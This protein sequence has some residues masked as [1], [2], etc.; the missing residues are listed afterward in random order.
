M[1]DKKQIKDRITDIENQMSLQD[2]WNDSRKAQEI[3]AEYQSLKEELKSGSKYS[4]NNAIVSIMAGAGG[5]DAEDFVTML[6]RMYERWATQHGLSVE[7]LSSTTSSAGYRSVSFLIVGSGAYGKLKGE[8]GVH[9]LVRISP[10]NAQGKRQTSFA[11]VE[12]VPE[13]KALPSIELN[14]SD[15]EVS[16]ARSGGA[17]GQNIN[18]VET[19]VRIKHRPSGISVKCTEGRTQQANRD[20]AMA[21]LLGKL[22]KKQEDDR[23][24]EAQGLSISADVDNSWGSQMRSYILHPYKKIKDHITGVETS[25]VDAVLDGDI[26][27]FL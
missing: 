13:L 7:I 11:M 8:S 17:G 5:D 16:F 24:K 22:Y 10:F 20:K 19:A 18:K 9:R 25:N 3:M 12:I 1:Q 27:I 6:K 4:N 14:D 26:S 15:L 21:L 2:F 23:T